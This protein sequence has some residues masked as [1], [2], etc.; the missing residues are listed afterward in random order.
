MNRK[1]CVLI[2]ILLFTFFFSFTKKIYAESTYRCGYAYCVGTQSWTSCVY[3]PDG[4][5]SGYRATGIGTGDVCC[6]NQ[7]CPSGYYDCCTENWGCCCPINNPPPPCT[8]GCTINCESGTTTTDYGLGSEEFTCRDDCDDVHRKTCYC[9]EAQCSNVDDQITWTEQN[10]SGNPGCRGP[11]NFLI[12]IPNSHESCPSQQEKTCY[13]HNNQKPLPP[14]VEFTP[15]EWILSQNNS[16]NKSTT[17]TRLLESFI[18]KT[19]AQEE[20]QN[21]LGF[22][23]STYSGKIVN[24]PVKVQATYKD[25]DGNDDILALYLWLTKDNANFQKP[26][27]INNSLSP[28]TNNDQNFGFMIYRTT[29]TNPWNVYIPH[30]DDQKAWVNLGNLQDHSTFDIKGSTGKKTATI[31]NLEITES[32][33]QINVNLFMQFFTE[34]DNDIDLLNSG[35][36]KVWALTDD[37][38]S[39]VNNDVDWTNTSQTW[40]IDLQKPSNAQV[41]VITNDVQ[42]AQ[43]LQITLNAIDENLLGPI[44]LDACRTGGTITDNI[45]I[46]GREYEIEDCDDKNF[47]G[48]TPEDIHMDNPEDLISPNSITDVSSKT[49]NTPIENVSLGNNEGG[50]ITFYFT[51]MDK[52]GNWIQGIKI[53]RLGEWAAVEN[54]LVFGSEGV[55]ST[56]RRFDNNNIWTNEARAKLEDPKYNFT[57]MTIDLTDTALLGG[58]SSYT[59][60]LGFLERYNENKSFKAARYSGPPLG[61]P[62]IELM[63]AF[64]FKSAGITNLSTTQDTNI[65]N[66]ISDYCPEEYCVISSTQDITINQGTVCDRKTLISSSGSITITPDFTNSDN[67]SACIILAGGNIIIEPGV[68]LP[69]QVNYDTIEAYMIANGQITIKGGDTQDGLRVEGGL[70]AFTPGNGYGSI[71]N[72]R[73]MQSLAVRNT[74]PILAIKTSSKYGILSKTLFGSQVNIFKTEV[75]FK[76]Y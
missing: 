33:T 45:Y 44:R 51:V 37:K 56:T 47:G 1:N 20:L 57:E 69:S 10:C 13:A 42:E 25:P 17:L 21:I 50:S 22:T 41:D 23:T 14:T 52:G 18:P 54:G 43:N 63:E 48:T 27:N 8:P 67:T 58:A 71:E 2:L 9:I 15:G 46:D 62:Y 16:I 4:K 5:C 38:V 60:F 39:W 70:V 11:S 68:D 40:N 74:Y 73:V 55:T 36:Y 19:N 6:L 65:S 28:E 76:P 31:H 66:N 34:D 3:G 75:G 61:D 26:E 53:Y 7:R 32:G 30:L 24:N 64:H 12:D 49:Y 35:Q 59:S 72:E 29:P